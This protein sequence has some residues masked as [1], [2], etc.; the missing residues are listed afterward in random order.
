METLYRQIQRR[1]R[2]S[3]KTI[4]KLCLETKVSQ[5]T[6]WRW[7]KGDSVPSI[8]VLLRLETR[9]RVWEREDERIK[10]KQERAAKQRSN[11][12]LVI[13]QIEGTHVGV[14]E[15]LALL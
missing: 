9:L 3:G 15:I 1:C 5:S 11:K 2:R 13:K 8:E 14:S 4:R 7:R 12:A 6:M 10:A